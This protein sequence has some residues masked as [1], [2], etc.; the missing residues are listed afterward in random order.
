MKHSLWL[1]DYIEVYFLWTIWRFVIYLSVLVYSLVLLWSE[2]SMW[3]HL[4]ELSWNLLLWFSTWSMSMKA[5][6]TF[7]NNIFQAVVEWSTLYMLIGS[8]WL[9]ML[10]RTSVFLLVFTPPNF[11]STK[12]WVLKSTI[13]TVQFL[14]FPFGYIYL[15]ASFF[16]ILLLSADILR[17]F[18]SSW[19]IDQGRC[20]DLQLLCQKYRWQPTTWK[21]L[22][23]WGGGQSVGQREGSTHPYLM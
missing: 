17:T 8:R 9:I 2:N 16:W 11:L 22:L 6:C 3:H 4:V 15:C 14:I 10:L 1:L 23:K 19:R 18:I 21:W 12:R 20:H 13:I 5:S 7:E